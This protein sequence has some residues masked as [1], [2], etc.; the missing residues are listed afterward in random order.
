[1]APTVIKWTDPNVPVLTRSASSLIGVLDYCLPLRGWEKVFSE[2]GK[3]VYRAGTGE[4]KLYRVLNDGSFYYNSTT[5]QY[6]HAKVTAYD[7]MSGIDTGSGQWAENYVCVSMSGTAVARPWICIVDE[8]GFWI[9]TFPAQVASG[10]AMNTYACSPSYFG[11]TIPALPGN[12]ARSVAAGGPLNVLTSHVTTLTAP[13]GNM[14]RVNRSL[15]GATLSIASWLTANGGS[16]YIDNAEPYG[17]FTLGGGMYPYPYNG[18]L[19]YGQP[20][21]NDAV[22]YSLGDFIP[23]LYYPLHKGSYFNNAGTYAAGTKSF[24]ALYIVRN[25]Y[26]INTSSVST[27]TVF[28]CML[29]DLSASFRP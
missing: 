16:P 29:I 7:S 21:L 3:A 11:E 8:K 13:S 27:P 26:G 9:I 22:A 20:L 6:C 25:S 23:G 17:H 18:D 19:L 5:Y 15:D 1:M 2:P 28:G 4:R 10:G 14:L 12:S 24:L